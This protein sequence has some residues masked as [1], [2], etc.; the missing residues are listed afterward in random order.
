MIETLAPA[1][2]LSLVLLG[3]HSWFGIEI[4]RRGI[5]F[6]DLAVG[7]MAAAGAAVSILWLDGAWL[8]P[9]SLTSAM[10]AAALIA[11]AGKR[12]VNLEA[13]IGLIYAFGFSASFLLLSRAPHGA[14]DFNRILAADILFT[15]MSEIWKVAAVYSILALALAAAM[16]HLTGRARDTAF[17]M[18][19]AATVTSSV[20][21]AGSLVVF[22]IL[23]APAFTVTA[24]GFRRTLA[25]AWGGGAIVCSGAIWISY[26]F[27]LPTGYTIV[28][29]SAAVAMM[30]GL[31][32]GKE[33]GRRL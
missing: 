13:F 9:L 7:Q 10:G 4:I 8:Y 28:F 23:I 32:A 21:L 16:N 12:P 33:W 25:W 14:E 29:I 5:I 26:T 22:S 3:I 2:L 19:F 30:A 15:P 11:F 18:I 31:V 6:T 20:R 17:F 24:L 27:D 1:L